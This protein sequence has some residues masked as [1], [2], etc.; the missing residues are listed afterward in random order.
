MQQEEVNAEDD[1]LQ[2]Q[3]ELFR[4]HRLNINTADVSDLEQLP[5]ISA[6][7]VQQLLL[8]R[9]LMGP[10]LHIYELQAVPGWS[11]ALIRSVMPYITVEEN[12]FDNAKREKWLKKGKHSVM[13]R[14]SKRIANSDS[15]DNL[16][17]DFKMLV[18]YR[19]AYRDRLQ[20]GVVADKDAGEPFFGPVQRAGFDFYSFHFFI[21]PKKFVQ[22]IALGDYTVNMGQGLIHWQR[23][24]FGKGAETAAAKRQAAVISPYQSAGEYLFHRGAAIGLKM[25]R[26]QLYMFLSYRK[27][28]ATID[29][30]D[31][32]VPL[33]FSTI[34][35]SGIH[36]TDGEQKGKNQLGQLA[37]GAVI[38]YAVAGFSVSANVIYHRFSIPM[39]KQDRPENYFAIRGRQWINGSVDYGYTW[40]NLHLFGE[41]AAD[42]RGAMASLQGLLLSLAPQLDLAL[43]RRDLAV[44]YQ[45]VAG[46][47]FTEST[48]PG[49]EKGTFLSLD[50]RPLPGVNVQTFL[51]QYFFPWIKSST[52]RPHRGG[53]FQLLVRHRLSKR[54]DY[55]FRWRQSWSQADEWDGLNN[56]VSGLTRSWRFHQQVWMNGKLE[57]RQ[58]AEFRQLLTPGQPAIYGW[59]YFTELNFA[60]P[61]K[62]WSGSLRLQY[63]DTDGYSARVYTFERDVLYFSALSAFY[64]RGYRLCLVTK[65]EISKKITA[66]LKGGITL[67]RGATDVDVRGNPDSI[68]I[69]S[70]IRLQ[71][72][73]DF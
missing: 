13:L 30:D 2:L 21:R 68:E 33:S 67:K 41:I 24:A 45:S 65:Y 35:T 23:M 9:G 5:F 62:P 17:S 11:P 66:W 15:R 14:Y 19:Y 27:L 53:D 16:P 6:Y 44:G 32:G 71:I 64:G 60:P 48:T 54:S 22:L 58:R 18:R 57:W 43:I 36:K 20:Y 4:K 26:W 8:Y 37:T 63:F 56:S 72:L 73:V 25:G 42:K 7:H 50:W 12:W 29:R 10:L 47:A 40:R 55:Y 46:Q 61:M 59:L 52:D 39:Q 28:S 3:A 1:A 38:R 69:I 31:S 49:N 70:E 51:D 34:R